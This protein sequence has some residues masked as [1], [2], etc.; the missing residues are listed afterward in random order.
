MKMPK[1]TE[2]SQQ[3][4]EQLLKSGLSQDVL[5]RIGALAVLWGVFETNLETTL[6]ALRGESVAS[7]RPSTDK[8]Q[9]GE[10]I[11][12]LG[13][14]WPKMAVEA[15]EVLHAAS[16]AASDLMDYRH[17]IMHGT[18]LP[19]A[20]MPSFIRNPRWHG[21]VR[22]RPT[23]DAHVDENLLDMAI[24]C[25]RVLCEAVFV[26]RAIC[27]ESGKSVNWK[28]LKKE[29]GRAVTQA[30]ELRHLTELMNHEKY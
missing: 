22:K 26:A 12:D 5:Q 4:R 29:V 10:W 27:I 8:S 30:G 14:R 1:H 15:N 20:A 18:L 2:H 13:K 6:W 11:K 19:A 9:V 17:A 25:A 24:D 16:L 3:I 28:A 7:V 21:E 23:H